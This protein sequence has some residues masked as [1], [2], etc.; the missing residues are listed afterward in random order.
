MAIV[1]EDFFFGELGAENS[2]YISNFKEA[3]KNVP[4]THVAAHI[5]RLLVDAEG[6]IP[7]TSGVSYERL[8]DV[9]SAIGGENISKL[10]I[11]TSTTA[12]TNVDY[13]Y[14]VDIYMVNGIVRVLGHWTD[15]KAGRFDEIIAYM[16]GGIYGN[17]LQGRTMVGVKDLPIDWLSDDLELV[18]KAFM[19]KAGNHESITCRLERNIEAL[20]NAKIA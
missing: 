16:L 17:N 6:F 9:I 15:Y 20:K 14:A 3:V 11:S 4:S 1:D 12:N 19:A 8:G 13:T 2:I 5:E 10:K 18:V 7:I